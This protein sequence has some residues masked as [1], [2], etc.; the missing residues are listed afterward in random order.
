MLPVHIFDTCNF[1]RQIETQKPRLLIHGQ[2]RNRGKQHWGCG[3]DYYIRTSS[4]SSFLSFDYTPAPK[5]VSG[6]LRANHEGG[7]VKPL[8]SAMYCLLLT[9]YC[10]SL[11]T[12][13]HSELVVTL[14]FLG[15]QSASCL[16]FPYI[17]LAIGHESMSDLSLF[18]WVGSTLW[19]S[20]K[21]YQEKQLENIPQLSFRIIISAV[22]L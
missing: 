15:Q 7:F 21:S 6:H 12:Q 22:Y 9:A 19:T 16:A 5:R 20:L 14:G 4:L 17:C 13:P 1:Q 11:Y 10:C 3:E 8:A 2:S 18:F